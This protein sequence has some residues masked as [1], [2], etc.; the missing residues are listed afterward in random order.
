MKNHLTIEADR[1]F[2]LTQLWFVPE[3]ATGSPLKFSTRINL[4][5]GSFPQVRGTFN[6]GK[7]PGIFDISYQQDKLMLSVESDTGLS[8]T[9]AVDFGQ[10]QK[11]EG[12]LAIQN[13]AINQ[14]HN[15]P[16]FSA[17][18]QFTG[19]ITGNLS[20]SGT[21][22]KPEMYFRLVSDKNVF[23]ENGYYQAGV[24]GQFKDQIVQLDSLHFSLNNNPLLEGA[25]RLDYQRNILSGELSGRS[26]D[27]EKLS[28]T[29]FPRQYRMAGTG[30]IN[31]HLSGT[32]DKP[33]LRTS[34]KISHGLIGKYPFNELSFSLTDRIISDEN[35]LNPK[36]HEI[37]VD[38]FRASQ[39]GLYHLNSH[40]TIPLDLNRPFDITLRGDG[41]L[42]YFL[43]DVAPFF[44]DG[45]CFSEFQIRVSGNQDDVRFLNGEFNI[46]R[47]ELWLK[48]VAP[49]IT[50][51]SGTLRLQTNSNKVDFENFSAMVEENTLHISTV[52]NIVTAGREKLQPWYFKGLDLDFGVL[53]LQTSAGGV[54]VHIP[55]LMP[56]NETGKLYLT[57]REE[58]ESFYFAGP[59]DHPRLRG[60]VTLYDTRITYP[61]IEDRKIS[62]NDP[63]IK[64]LRDINWD[65]MV[66]SGENVRYMRD[67]PAYF[68]KVETELFVDELSP[69]LALTGIISQDKFRPFGQ[70]SSSRG[71]LEYLDQSFRLDYFSVEFDKSSLYPDVSGQ[72]W[73]TIRDSV[74]SISKTIYLKLFVFDETT[75]QELSQG[76]WTNFKFKL[77]SSDPQIGE[78]QEL[79]LAYMGYSVQNLSEK[80]TSVGGA[81]T[82]KYLIRPLLRPI[83]RAIER[84]LNLDLVRFN[85]SIARNL[86]YSSLVNKNYGKSHSLNYIQPFSSTAP[87]LLLMQSSELTLGKY[88]SPNVYLTYTGQLVSVYDENTN[89]FDFNHS[90]GLEYRFFRNVLIELE[91]DRE[92]LGFYNQDNQKQY[93]EDFKIRLR[94]SFTF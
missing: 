33:V 10:M 84:N 8:G 18:D 91:Y 11:L 51:I 43:P 2:V 26:I 21:L 42:F 88:L 27:V 29:F 44:I 34:A 14:F 73:T 57:G 13:L 19:T 36:N 62:P 40:G 64:F 79:V 75:G 20:V 83:E 4:R 82:E 67:I 24:S 60:T 1:N 93:L 74:G 76:D 25:V 61:M 71:R 3:K 66:R 78:S 89:N 39:Q 69:G 45:T 80:A 23:N 54:K 31:V 92:L 32:T 49:H 87:Y 50:D 28:A 22:P 85:S 16:G 47:G 56:G 7:L 6:V 12:N 55:G 90:V 70:L 17:L 65:L 59:T 30:Q 35:L 37:V 63:V 52:R 48:D 53:R 41:D 77:V 68:D 38:Y 46:S 81:V 94:H 15:L 86:F 72:A 9:A 58:G 5:A